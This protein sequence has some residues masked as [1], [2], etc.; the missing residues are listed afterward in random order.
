MRN[1]KILNRALERLWPLLFASICL[2][3]L[4]FNLRWRNITPT[5]MALAGLATLPWSLRWFSSLVQSMKFGGMELNFRQEMTKK[6][7]EHEKAVAAAL[8]S[9]IGKPGEKAPRKP[10][11]KSEAVSHGVPMAAED[12]ELETR[13]MELEED[14]DAGDPNKGHF[15]GKALAASRRLAATVKPFP[16][17]DDL[18]RIQA[19]VASVNASKPLLDG[20][21]V[22]FH[23]HPTFTPPVR[24]VEVSHGAARLE[25]VA[26]GAFTIGVEIEGEDLC[27]EL[28]LAKDVPD[29]P[30]LFVQR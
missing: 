3:L 20:T 29:A 17:S 8:T 22:I 27:L 19:A 24:K 14:I 6:L 2:V 5:D 25:C 12:A 23:L 18:F 15:G 26:W 1:L 7:V 10:R 28:D 13:S 9:G 30:A 11:K 4:A 16:G 21:P